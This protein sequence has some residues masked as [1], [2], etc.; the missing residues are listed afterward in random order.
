M[1]KYKHESVTFTMLTF[2]LSVTNLHNFE[3][4]GIFKISSYV[5]LVRPL[6]AYCWQEI[7]I[8]PEWYL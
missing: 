8:V 6:R 1:G 5:N 3:T 2:N 4:T 7:A